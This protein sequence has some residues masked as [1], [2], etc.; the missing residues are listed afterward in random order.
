MTYILSKV[1]VNS[2]QF[3]SSFIFMMLFSELEVISYEH[4]TMLKAF[5]V[6]DDTNASIGE[7]RSSLQRVTHMT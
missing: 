6:F 3:R 2:P 1:I 5:L 7:G 4:E